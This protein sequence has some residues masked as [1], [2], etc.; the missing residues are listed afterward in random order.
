MVEKLDRFEMVFAKPEL[1]Y[2][3]ALNPNLTS[4]QV[5]RI[6]DDSPN[7]HTKRGLAQNSKL[8][9]RQFGYL[10]TATPASPYQRE[11]SR[12]PNLTSRQIDRVIAWGKKGG[13]LHDNLALNAKLSDEQLKR[14]DH[15]QIRHNLT[16]NT[17]LTTE[18]IDSLYEDAL[19]DAWDTD[20]D[21]LAQNPK[22]TE[23]QFERFWDGD[24]DYRQGHGHQSYLSDNPHLTEDQ[25]D[26]LMKHP[27]A[28]KEGLSQYPKLTDEQFD[29]LFNDEIDT[30]LR[31]Y[32]AKNPNIT[33]DQITRLYDI[34]TRTTL[35][36]RVARNLFQFPQL[37]DAQFQKF[38]SLHMTDEIHE[39]AQQRLAQN[40]SINPDPKEVKDWSANTGLIN[41]VGTTW[42]W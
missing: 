11:F 34:A 25:I 22:L 30:R 14:I 17:Q 13:N 5:Q 27:D 24:E 33:P 40:P 6:L 15:R 18:Q 16:N 4:E 41:W 9:E 37:T 12:N 20:R 38:F 21:Y 10:E 31:G 7:E 19:K 29:E 42:A 1:R 28:D 8:T 23:E 32:L 3:L 26:R 2:Y 35:G 36:G 39:D